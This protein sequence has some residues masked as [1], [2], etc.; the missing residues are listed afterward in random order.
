MA[1]G[2]PVIASDSHLFDDL[3]G[4]VPKAHDTMTLADEIAKVFEKS[5]VSSFTAWP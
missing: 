1:N 4:V 5:R 2:I 3:E